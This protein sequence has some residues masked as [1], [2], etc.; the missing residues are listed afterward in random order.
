MDYT[1]S[2]ITSPL[3]QYWQNFV[4]F[5][6]QLIGALVVL[7]VGL[8]VA[9]IIAAIIKKLIELGES[10][11]H[12]VKF[13]KNWN[14]RFKASKF[15]GTFVWW[16]IFLVFIS[17]AAQILQVQVLTETINSLVDY[18]PALFAAALV[19]ALTM[20]G[21]HVLRGLIVEALD[22]VKF[23]G[24]KVVGLAVYVAVLVFGFTIAASQLGIETSLITAN[25]T[26]IVAGVVFA[27]AL[28]F[29]LGGKEVAGRIVED[30]YTSTKSKRR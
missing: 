30:V 28:A 21:A 7:V 8:I 22:G 16:V 1:V 23:A 12:V 19:A 13:L 10:N 20:V 15:V 24:S 5:V 18:T 17:A 27:L 9:S 4:D 14:I 2:S 29:G 26:V 11:R 6:P 25:L 3:E